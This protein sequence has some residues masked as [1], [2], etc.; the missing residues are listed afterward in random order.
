MI[1][2]LHGTSPWVIAKTLLMQAG[3][4]PINNEPD[5]DQFDQYS[6]EAFEIDVE[7]IRIVN[8]GVEHRLRITK[9][10]K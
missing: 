1:N 4:G 2:L 7:S 5:Q 6:I 10:T 8:H 9:E 3:I